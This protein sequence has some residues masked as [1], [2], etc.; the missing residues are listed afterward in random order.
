MGATVLCNLNTGGQRQLS[1]SDLLL[2]WNSLC[3]IPQCLWFSSA[4]VGRLE[5]IGVIYWTLRS[6]ETGLSPTEKA[7]IF[8]VRY[9]YYRLHHANTKDV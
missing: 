7:I 2:S 8:Q 4:L 3:E 5:I 1:Y 6:W 9:H